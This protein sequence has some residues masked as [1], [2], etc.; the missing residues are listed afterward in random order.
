[1]I[2]TS[3]PVIVAVEGRRPNGARGWSW[4]LT[5]EDRA[6]LQAMVRDGTAST[7]QRRDAAAGEVVL[8]A[9][10]PA[11]RL[12]A[13]AAAAQATANAGRKERGEVQIVRSDKPCRPLAGRTH[14]PYTGDVYWWTEA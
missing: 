3:A 14:A 5:D 12:A 2:L 9:W 8:L 13:E 10:S 6:V 7:Y 4:S 11:A 1:M